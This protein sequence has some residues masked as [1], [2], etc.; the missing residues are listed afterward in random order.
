MLSA[1]WAGLVFGRSS[2]RRGADA[3][4]GNY[5]NYNYN[6][7][8]NNGRGDRRRRRRLEIGAAQGIGV[9]QHRPKLAGAELGQALDGLIALSEAGE[10]QDG[11]IEGADAADG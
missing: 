9:F 1:G 2:E 6:Y 4:G 11:L 10:A 5:Y 3:L 8:Y 7:N